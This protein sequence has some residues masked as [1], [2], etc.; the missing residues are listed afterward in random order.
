M[1]LSENTNLLIF[2]DTIFLSPS[3]LIYVNYLSLNFFKSLPTQ[4]II[5]IVPTFPQFP[6]PTSG[7]LG[8]DPLSSAVS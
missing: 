1:N 3:P 6:L 2:N 7:L 4:F 8:S 5:P